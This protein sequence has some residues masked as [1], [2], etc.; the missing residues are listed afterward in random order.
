M[1]KNAKTETTTEEAKKVKVSD[2]QYVNG[3]GEV[4]NTVQPD[5]SVIRVTFGNGVVDDF[6]TSEVSADML[7]CATLQGFAI[8]LQRSFASAKGDADEAY[9]AYMKTKE[10]ILA[11]LWNTKREGSGP[12]LS[13][14][15]EAIVAGLEEQGE[16]VDEKRLA[17]IGEKVKD[18]ERREAA[19][20]MPAV[21]KH[22]ERIKA[23]RAAERAAAAAKEAEAS[24]AKL[25][26]F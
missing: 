10:N 4:S 2:I 20:K 18:E 9:E 26:D 1:A 23:A 8:K 11:G 17:A 5:A 6:N 16:T 19:M 22:Y 21:K 25:S 7:H 24:D 15:I 12:R 13:I 3:D 14:L